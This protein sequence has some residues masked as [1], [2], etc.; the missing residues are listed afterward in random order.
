M[1][2][3]EVNNVDQFYKEALDA[4]AHSIMPPQLMPWGDRTCH[5]KDIDSYLW[6]FA[7]N[8]KPCPHS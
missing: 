3:L 7:S 6:A 2:L 1:H 8:I 5:L 4:G